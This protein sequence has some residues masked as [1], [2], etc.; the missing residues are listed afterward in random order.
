[1]TILAGNLRMPALQT[2]GEPIVIEGAAIA[3]DPIVAGQAIPAEDQHVPGCKGCPRIR[4]AIQA[5]LHGEAVNTLKMAILTNKSGAIGSCLMSGER[6][7]SPFV[8]KFIQAYSG[9]GGLVSIMVAVAL[10]AGI[11][12]PLSQ[13]NDVE[14]FPVAQD[15]L[16]AYEAAV[17]HAF[18][19]P[20][21]RMAGWTTTAKLAMSPDAS[22]HS[23]SL[24]RIQITRAEHHP[25]SGQEHPN[26]HQQRNQASQQA[27]GGQATKRFLFPL[28]TSLSARV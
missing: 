3:V 23:V 11:L 7:S 8:W 4:V 13:H 16:V 22:Q 28:H 25:A 15:R 9:Q 10:A 20:N 14:I 12:L 27:R 2:E 21:R 6:K 17:G 19:T 24:D 1:M 26:D 5:G 18:P